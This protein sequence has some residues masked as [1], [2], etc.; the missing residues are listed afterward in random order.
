MCKR[1]ALVSSI[2]PFPCQISTGRQAIPKE[3]NDLFTFVLGQPGGVI[4]GMVEG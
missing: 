1:L 3:V 2:L 4:S